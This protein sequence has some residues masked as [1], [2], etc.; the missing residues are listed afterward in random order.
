MDFQIY[1]VS[2]GMKV[3]LIRQSFRKV[4]SE[5]NQRNC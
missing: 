1:G 3:N 5:L 4:E 2:V